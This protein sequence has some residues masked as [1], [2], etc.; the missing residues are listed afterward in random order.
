MKKINVVILLLS[1]FSMSAQ[2][3]E[4]EPVKNLAS[5]YRRNIHSATSLLNDYDQKFVHIDVS[6]SDTA[7]Y[8]RGSVKYLLEV[9][10]PGFDT[11]LFEF[12]PNSTFDSIPNLTI[13]SIHYNNSPVTYSHNWDSI[14][15]FIPGNPPVNSEFEVQVWYHGWSNTGGLYRG[16]TRTW[17]SAYDYYITWT[18]SESFHLKDWLPCKQSLSDRLDSAWI[19]ITVDTLLKAGSNGILT[20]ITDMGNGKSRYEWKTRHKIVYYL[21]SL[22]VGKYYEYNIYAKPQGY[23]D[24]I[25]IQNYI[26]N[27]PQCINDNLYLIDKTPSLI[28]LYSDK[29]GLYPWHD[30]KYGH[31][32]CPIGGGMEHQTMT[33]LGYFDTWLVAHELAHQWFGNNIT[34]ATWQDIW[35]N[36]GFASYAEYIYAQ[37]MISQANADANMLFC[38]KKAKLEPEGS[39][40]IPFEQAWDEGRIFNGNLSYKK[41]SALIHTI[42]YLI[43][44]DS[45]FYEALKQLNTIYAD[46]IL[47]GA[48]AKTV[49]ENTSGIELDDVFNQYYYGK[50][51]PVY[52]LTWYQDSVGGSL[53]NLYINVEHRGSSSSN[54]LFTLPLQFKL[55]FSDSSDSIVMVQPDVNIQLFEIPTGKKVTGIELDPL[56]WLLDSLESITHSKEKMNFQ[57]YNF[58]IFPNPASDYF[59]LNLNHENSYKG[60]LSIYDLTGRQVFTKAVSEKE[61]LVCVKNILSGNYIVK[62]QLDEITG[63]KQLIIQH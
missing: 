25:L 63:Y 32:M 6:V 40:Y 16:L 38:H 35:I 17:S 45:L 19:F 14:L 61:N 54:N 8:I 44:N 53:G 60:I 21:L 26:Y 49:F 2:Y 47:T 5:E 48:D 27:N 20:N 37:N 3:Y 51:Y 18:L 42:R 52:N 24:S 31:S 22:A 12:A 7:R 4:P 11:L 10:S 59:S 39:I 36:E 15:V 1:A 55:S 46:S 33:S 34:C 29:F 57:R 62:I 9:K 50:G 43:N 41:G 28:N 13:D 30:E 23:S 58:T 56:N